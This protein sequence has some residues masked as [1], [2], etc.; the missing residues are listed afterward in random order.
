MSDLS[1]EIIKL[2]EE[3]ATKLRETKELERLIEIKNAKSECS[4]LEKS[5]IN[6]GVINGMTHRECSVLASIAE[7][8]SASHE[9]L[10]FFD[11]VAN[12]FEDARNCNKKYGHH[13]RLLIIANFYGFIA[14][15]Y[16]SSQFSDFPSYERYCKNFIYRKDMLLL[17][18]HA[19]K[20]AEKE[21]ILSKDFNSGDKKWAL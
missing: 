15:I 18:Y 1:E 4:I 9:A 7:Y 12:L 2:T 6:R 5:F 13:N 14:H 3:V 21:E 8:V 16:N 20:H 19:E 11:A 10:D 17:K